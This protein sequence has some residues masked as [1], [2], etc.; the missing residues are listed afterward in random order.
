MSFQ[1][2]LLQKEYGFL[3]SFPTISN[4]SLNFLVQL[5]DDLGVTRFARLKCPGNLS[6]FVFIPRNKE[7]KTYASLG[8]SAN[9]RDDDIL[10]L[11]DVIREHLASLFPGYTVVS[12]G[13]FR[14]TRNTDVEIEE[15]EADDLLEAVKDLVEQRRFGDVCVSSYVSGSRIKSFVLYNTFVGSFKSR[16]AAPTR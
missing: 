5:K 15:D 8:F 14:I 11:E 12:E 3:C 7:A 13:L 10:L 16:R 6:R 4:I 9:V 2:C 1:I